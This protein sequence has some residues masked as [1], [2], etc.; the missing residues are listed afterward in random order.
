MKFTREM[1]TTLTIRSVSQ[2]E[3]RIGDEVYTGTIALTGDT[4]FADWP[5]KPVGELIDSDF[6]RL[7]ETSPEIIVLGTGAANIFP[8]RDLVF[9]MARRGI[10]FEVMDTRAAART[11]NVLA[12]EDRNVAAVLYVG[13]PA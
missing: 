1:P 4:V 2:E 3:I 10:G 11:F 7:L 6:S 8:P 12:G 9:A 13:S 5:V